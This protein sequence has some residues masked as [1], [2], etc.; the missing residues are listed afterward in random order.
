MKKISIRLF[1]ITLFVFLAGSYLFAKVPV[2]VLPFKGEASKIEALFKETL[3]RTGGLSIISESMLKDVMEIHEK[4]Q[5]LG[6][7]YHDISELKTAEYLISGYMKSGNLVIS[8]VDVN[9]GAEIFT[10]TMKLTKRTGRYEMGRLCS[11]LQDAILM[12]AA[13]KN[14]E[15]SEEAEEYMEKVSGLISSLRRG[16]AASYPYIALYSKGK[17][18]IPVKGKA[19][20]ERRAK[21]LLRIVRKNLIRTKPVFLYMETK[22]P[23]VYIYVVAKKFGK[24]KKHIFGFIEMEDGSLGIAIYKPG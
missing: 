21:H 20:L 6:S 2:G 22:E 9:K 17:Y 1:A 19:S 14:R 13:S 15:V 7:A 18:V 4:A 8:A 16:N 3:L 23:W 5:S 24:K 11:K 12:H 10:R